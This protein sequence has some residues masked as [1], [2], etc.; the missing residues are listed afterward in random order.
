VRHGLPTPYAWQ[1]EVR[2]SA[3]SACRRADAIDSMHLIGAK[4]GV[5]IN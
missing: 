4:P 5:K 1:G 3:R 2:S